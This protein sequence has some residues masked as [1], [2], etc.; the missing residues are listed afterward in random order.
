MSGRTATKPTA[1]RAK[2]ADDYLDLVREFPLRPF[3][4]KQEYAAAQVMLD[5]LVGRE[6]LTAGQRDYVAALV[7]FVEDYEQERF[8]ALAMELGPLD[9]LKH[10]MEENDMSTTD[11]GYIVGSRGLASEILNGKR[12]LSKTVIARLSERFT[13][14]PA[15]FLDR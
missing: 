10:L 12:G 15:V 6:D 14:E 13:V 8:S 11:L 5:R 1:A 9:L 7:R 3:A 4:S 2:V